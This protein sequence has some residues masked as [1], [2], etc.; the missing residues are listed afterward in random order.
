M[1][2]VSSNCGDESALCF[3]FYVSAPVKS[4]AWSASLSMTDV[5]GRKGASM[6]FDLSSLIMRLR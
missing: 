6:H 5:F 4:S 1:N 3:V 2:K